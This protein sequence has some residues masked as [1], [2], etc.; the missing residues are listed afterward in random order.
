MIVN[1]KAKKGRDNIIKIVKNS[2]VLSWAHV[3]LHGEY[4]FNNYVAN[5]SKFNLDEI[6]ELNI[7]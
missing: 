2:S 7:A 5:D 3:N 6:L 1:N 4:D